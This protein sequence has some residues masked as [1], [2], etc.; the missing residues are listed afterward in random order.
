MQDTNNKGKVLSSALKIS[1][2][3]CSACANRVE[4]GIAALPGVESATVNYATEKLSVAYDSAKITL[5]EVTAK[6]EQLGYQVVKEKWE[7]NITGMSCAACS[8]RI[9]KVLNKMPG[10]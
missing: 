10:V 1:G 5:K 9:E 8:T 4:K 6:V 2:M 3:S 7:F